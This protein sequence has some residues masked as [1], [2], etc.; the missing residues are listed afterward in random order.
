MEV[1]PLHSEDNMAEIDTSQ[2]AKNILGQLISQGLN[3]LQENVL[4]TVQKKQ[5]EQVE[6]AIDA[7]VPVENIL[8]QIGVPL[9]EGEAVQ[10]ISSK[11]SPAELTGDER[12]VSPDPV[13]QM[14]QILGGLIRQA[15]RQRNIELQNAKLEQE[16]RGQ[17]PIQQKDIDSKLIQG[18]IDLVKEQ[19]KSGTLTANN[20]F[21][22]YEPI[23]QNFQGIVNSYARVQA[24]VED[25]SAAGDLA[26]IFNFMKILDPNSVVRESEFATAQNAGSID[27]RTRGLYN[28]VVNGKRLSD[29][30]RADF[31]NR[32]GKLFKSKERQFKGA[33]K[34]Y[35][36]IARK[37]NISDPDKIIRDVQLVE[38]QSALQ[39]EISGMSDAELQKIVGGN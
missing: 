32:A 24:S 13:P 12:S 3:P 8:Q 31:A 25:P 16:L 21:K 37:N 36:N 19:A 35:Q 17:T 7:G 9:S 14:R 6:Q 30:Q 18:Q 10:Q 11:K 22:S 20:I 33:R 29:T 27:E 38:K 28:S 2:K 23:A 26:L 5:S 34:N 4:K 39:K 15:P 1:D